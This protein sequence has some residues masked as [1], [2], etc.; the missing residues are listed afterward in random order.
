MLITVWNGRDNVII[1]TLR[2]ASNDPISISPGDHI[3]VKIGTE[4]NSPIL[5]MVGATATSN[6]TIF[7]NTNPFTIMFHR[8][9]V[10]LLG[11]GIHQMEVL[12]Y[13]DSAADAFHAE[14]FQL[15]VRGTMGGPVT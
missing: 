8:D 7:Q 12:V 10:A 14:D 6:G 13:D 4:Q 15:E 11:K 1:V 2:N 5:D 9:D 3:R